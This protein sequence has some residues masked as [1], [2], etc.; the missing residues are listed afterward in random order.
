MFHKRTVKRPV[1]LLVSAT[2]SNDPDAKGLYAE[3]AENPGNNMS[4]GRELREFLLEK[5]LEYYPQAANVPFHTSMSPYKILLPLHVAI[6][7]REMTWHKGG[8]QHLAL[9]SVDVLRFSD[10]RSRLPPALQ[11]ATHAYKS[12]M[13]LSTTYELLR[14]APEVLQEGFFFE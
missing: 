3:D 14:L 4:K 2:Q 7:N 8:I 13:H 9:A 6:A 5:L 1:V 10:P 12:R 11:S